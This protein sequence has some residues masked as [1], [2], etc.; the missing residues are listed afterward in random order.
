[1]NTKVLVLGSGGQLPSNYVTPEGDVILTT[2][3]DAPRV[4]ISVEDEPQQ[5]VG[6]WDGRKERWGNNK[7]HR[8]IA[9]RDQQRKQKKQSRKRNK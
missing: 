5:E 9:K 1:M 4:P 3:L 6:Y 2:V 7:A 8:S